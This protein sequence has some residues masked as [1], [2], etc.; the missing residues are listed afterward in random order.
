MVGGVIMDKQKIIDYVIYTP[1]NTNKNVLS[2][3]LD[4][5]IESNPA[6]NPEEDYIINSGEL[7]SSEED[8]EINFNGGEL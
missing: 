2:T 5:L 1:G 3:M 7:E 8:K 6:F 4:Q